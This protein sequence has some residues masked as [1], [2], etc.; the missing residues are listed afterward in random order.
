VVGEA[1]AELLTLA[2]RLDREAASVRAAAT[3]ARLEAVSLRAQAMDLRRLA[4]RPPGWRPRPTVATV[5]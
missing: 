2:A 1:R 3:D 4:R 5:F